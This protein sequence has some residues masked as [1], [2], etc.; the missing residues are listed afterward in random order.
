MQVKK[1]LVLQN[2]SNKSR[3][4]SEV[5]CLNTRY[6]FSNKV[7]A[8]F[9]L[10]VVNSL[11]QREIIDGNDFIPALNVHQ[12]IPFNDAQDLQLALKKRQ[13]TNGTPTSKSSLFLNEKASTHFTNAIQWATEPTQLESATYSDGGFISVVAGAMALKQTIAVNNQQACF[14]GATLLNAQNQTGEYVKPALHENVV[15]HVFAPNKDYGI[16][17]TVTTLA[18]LLQ[19]R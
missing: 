6:A 19:S 18:S 15:G 17:V 10:G 1:S 11:I 16:Q 14:A 12:P 4:K 7:E 5:L 2:T 9:A 3:Q 13:L 8:M